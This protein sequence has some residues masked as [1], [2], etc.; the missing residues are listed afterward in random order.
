MIKDAR[1]NVIDAAFM[2][3]LRYWLYLL[4][5]TCQIYNNLECV[6][7]Y[8]FIQFIHYLFNFILNIGNS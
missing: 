4:E 6:L 1:T 3:Y 5:K 8:F 2:E 7:V